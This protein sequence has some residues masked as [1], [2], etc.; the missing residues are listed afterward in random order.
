M[1]PGLPR[2]AVVAAALLALAMAA[3]RPACAHEVHEH[4]SQATATVVQLRY[5]DDEPFAFERYELFADGS[6]KLTL[7]GRTDAQ[8]RIVFLPDATRRWRLRAFSADGHGVD[9]PIEL[10]QLAERGPMTAVAVPAQAAQPARAWR[11]ALGGL[12]I[13][14]VAVALRVWLRRSHRRA[15]LLSSPLSSPQRPD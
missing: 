11:I 2:T 10:A 4:V 14:A 12:A 8:G 5:A 1:R 3:M 13:A 9:V 15:S 6:D 7:S